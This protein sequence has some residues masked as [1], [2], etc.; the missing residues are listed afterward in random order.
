MD[1]E[2]MCIKPAKNSIRTADLHSSWFVTDNDSNSSTEGADLNLRRFKPLCLT[3][4]EKT[5]LL[6]FDCDLDSPTVSNKIIEYFADNNFDYIMPDCSKHE[7]LFSKDSMS[8]H[9]S[10]YKKSDIITV[11]LSLQKQTT[12]P[13]EPLSLQKPAKSNDSVCDIFYKLRNVF[14]SK[15]EPVIENS[16]MTA[17]EIL[18]AYYS[19]GTSPLASHNPSCFA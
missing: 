17:L 12:V 6:N 5:C 15:R 10:L 18:F 4:Q 11:C 7:Y 2:P 16:N 3:Y 1:D 8:I 14:I 9:C 19:E 13:L